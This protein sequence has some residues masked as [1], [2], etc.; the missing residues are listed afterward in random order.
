MSREKPLMSEKNAEKIVSVGAEVASPLGENGRPVAGV[1]D[2]L[3]QFPK[4]GVATSEPA[5]HGITLWE[6]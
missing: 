3:P 1:S 5:I 2:R 4:V 6:Q